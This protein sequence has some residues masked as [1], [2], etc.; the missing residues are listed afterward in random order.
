MTRKELVG[1]L[2]DLPR[3]IVNR[4]RGAPATRNLGCEHVAGQERLDDRLAQATQ[5]VTTLFMQQC[6]EAYR[7]VVGDPGLEVAR[8]E[9]DGLDGAL[10]RKADIFPKR[11]R[12]RRPPE[13]SVVRK[14]PGPN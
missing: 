10:R 7:T 11:L 5:Y 3:A 4:G 8:A 13:R 14:T 12:R 9:I 1:Q 2:G 6:V